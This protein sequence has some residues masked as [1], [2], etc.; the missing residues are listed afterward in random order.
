M[1]DKN[2]KAYQ[3]RR[4][5]F[6]ACHRLNSPFLSAIENENTYGKCN[7]ING[8]GHNYTVKVTLFGEIHPQTGMIMN[9]TDLKKNMQEA[10]MKPLDHKN[11]D[12]DVEYFKLNP[13]TTENLTVFIWRQMKQVMEKPEL[14]YEVEVHET[15]NNIVSYRGD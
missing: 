1:G 15:E 2:P 10:I 6:S 9:M 12:A 11:L 3:T 14:L 5:T 7:H 13:S 4:M 8:H